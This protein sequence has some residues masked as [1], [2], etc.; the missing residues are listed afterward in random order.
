M[1]STDRR[2]AITQLVRDPSDLLLA[3]GVALLTQVALLATIT[4]LVCISLGWE[5]WRGDWGLLLI[6]VGV[7]IALVAFA[8]TPVACWL[9]LRA[10]HRPAAGLTGLLVVPIA[11]I[12]GAA[13]SVAVRALLGPGYA[14]TAG[15][16]GMWLWTLALW[17]LAVPVARVMALIIWAHRPTRPPY[18]ERPSTRVPSWEQP[19]ADRDVR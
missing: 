9:A 4:G 2:G 8:G 17:A 19:V 6:V 12:I 1:P 10:A 15:A 11:W 7:V 18:W 3:V 5:W 14:S 16:V 13:L